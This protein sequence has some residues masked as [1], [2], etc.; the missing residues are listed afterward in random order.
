MPANLAERR[1]DRERH[2]V[3]ATRRLFDERGMQDAPVEAIAREVGINKALIYRQL[4]SKEELFM[5]TLV[6]YLD[7]LTALAVDRGDCADPEG[8]LRESLR[9]FTGF[10]LEYPAYL[11]CAH[12]LMRLPADE[13]RTRVADDVWLRLGYAMAGALRPLA[14][15]L[16]AGR[17][18]GVFAIDDPDLVANR[19]YAQVLGTMRLSRVGVGVRDRDGEPELFG[20]DAERLRA[21]CVED[22]MALARVRYAAAG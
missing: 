19:L 7:D 10:C 14:L 12:T 13:L 22:A 3:S 1:R 11:D 16:E 9:R 18:Q 15:I 21:D 2:L 8:L 4:G 20:I 17:D 5:L 6:D